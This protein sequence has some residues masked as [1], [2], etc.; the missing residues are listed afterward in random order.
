M[1]ELKGYLKNFNYPLVDSMTEEQFLEIFNKSNRCFLVSWLLQ[2]VDEKFKKGPQTE[3]ALG[4]KLYQLGFVNEFEKDGFMTGELHPAKQFNILI[5]VFEYISIQKSQVV[6]TT[7]DIDLKFLTSQDLNLFPSYGNIKLYE[8]GS[9]ELLE[10]KD[11]VP[12]KEDIAIDFN[13]MSD[14]LKGIRECL[15]EV[16]YKGEKLIEQ[17]KETKTE[18]KTDPNDVEVIHKCN[19]NLKIIKQVKTFI[20]FHPKDN[21]V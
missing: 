9:K 1:E 4:Q 8:E 5:T 2:L 20:C 16:Q 17:E 18:L 12:R 6:D 21:C 11:G 10:K 15:P 3:K 7:V 19:S 13:D 14:V